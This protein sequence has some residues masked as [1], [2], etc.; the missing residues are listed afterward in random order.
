MES[1]Y[2]ITLEITTIILMS[3]KW[4]WNGFG[5]SRIIPPSLFLAL[6][7]QPHI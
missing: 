4:Y 7:V 3:N 6:Y 1:Q 5:D 2:I